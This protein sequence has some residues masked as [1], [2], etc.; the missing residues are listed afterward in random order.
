[1]KTAMLLIGLL[2]CTYSNDTGDSCRTWIYTPKSGEPFYMPVHVKD[3]AR[4]NALPPDARERKLLY[5]EH[6]PNR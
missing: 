6:M 5:L 1:M 3:T 4:I 2:I